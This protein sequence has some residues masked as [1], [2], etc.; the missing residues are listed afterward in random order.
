MSSASQNTAAR[1]STS[2]PLQPSPNPAQA[3]EPQQPSLP[4]PNRVVTRS[5]HNIY[6]PKTILDFMAHLSPSITPTNF[7]QPN[8][9]PEWQRAMKNEFDALLNNQTWDLVPYDPT[10]N[11]VS[12]KWLY[13]LKRKVD[14]TI[15]RYKARLVAKGFTHRPG[16][17]Y[18]ATFSPVIK[19]T[20]VV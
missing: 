1:P 6:K 11:I 2:L 5:Q 3:T 17:D 15:D 20:T 4:T 12:C 9:H 8:K 19:P 13:R 14:G 18:H 10:K 16:V 7:K